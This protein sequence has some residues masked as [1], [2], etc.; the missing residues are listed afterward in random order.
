MALVNFNTPKPRPFRYYP[1]YY[2][3]RKER[4]EEM[5]AKAKAELAA[6]KNRAEATG[7]TGNLQRGFLAENRA[8]S[9]L[10]RRKLE[11]RSALRFLIILIVLLGIFYLWQPELFL[12]FWRIK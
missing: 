4:L 5:K 1:R 12:A 7:Y 2:D 8:N 11:Q 6:E 9:K 3:E 10:Y